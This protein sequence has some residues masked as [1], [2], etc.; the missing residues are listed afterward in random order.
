[1]SVEELYEKGF[2][3]RCDGRYDEARGIF[4]QVLGM[5]PSHAN[6]KWQIGLIQCFVG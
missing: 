3:L 6:S 4:M 2:A 5:D 1:M